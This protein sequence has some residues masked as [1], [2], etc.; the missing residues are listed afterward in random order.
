MRFFAS[1]RMT[2]FSQ[3]LTG[4][5]QPPCDLLPLNDALFKLAGYRDHPVNIIIFFHASRL[6]HEPISR[7]SAAEKSLNPAV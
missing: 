1:L 5:S 4:F 2:G 3:P 7:N 6:A